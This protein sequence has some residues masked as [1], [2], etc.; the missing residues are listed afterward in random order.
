MRDFLV[1]HGVPSDAI[2]I[3][4]RSESTRENA[5]FVREL[6]SGMSGTRVLLTSDYHMFRATRAFRQAGVAIEPR[7]FPDAIK[8]SQRLAGRMPAF[9]NE[10]MEST[11]IVY[12]FARGW[13]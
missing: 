5:L 4:S 10:A 13:I 12:Y 2:Q 1:Y 8:R 9:I 6:L 7:P 3:E 11:K